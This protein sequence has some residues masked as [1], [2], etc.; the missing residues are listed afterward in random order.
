MGPEQPHVDLTVFLWAVFAVDASYVFLAAGQRFFSGAYPA[1]RHHV[2]RASVVVIALHV[3]C[4]GT[5]VWGGCALWLALQVHWTAATIL[6]CASNLPLLRK[7]PGARLLNVPLYVMITVY[8]LCRALWLLDALPGQREREFLLLWCGVSTFIWVRCFLC[9]FMAV[10]SS[11]LRDAGPYDLFYS[12]ALPYSGIFGIILPAAAMGADARWFLAFA[13]V[14]VL[15]PLMLAIH[16]AC[17]AMSAWPRVK[18]NA[19]CRWVLQSV[20]DA[21]NPAEYHGSSS[22]QVLPVVAP[23]PPVESKPTKA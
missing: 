20:M 16:K 12:V 2:D 23:P 22:V 1:T 10:T 7:I 5:V 17:L 15:A 8:N 18:H 19:L 6:H 13:S 14:A 11:S 3:L 9:V 4:G 21:T